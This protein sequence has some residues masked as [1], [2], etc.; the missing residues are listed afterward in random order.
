MKCFVWNVALYGTE[1]WT[2]R[3]KEQKQ[4]EAF[5]MW[6]WGR[7]KRVKWKDIIKNTVVIKRVGKERI[8][9]GLIKKRKRN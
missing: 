3:R 6:K 4:L 5:E 1:T 2:L 9:L 8:M 7:M